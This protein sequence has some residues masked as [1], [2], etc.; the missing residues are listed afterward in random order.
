MVRVEEKGPSSL[1]A[2]TL[3][4]N[5]LGTNPTDTSHTLFATRRCLFFIVF[6]LNEDFQ[7]SKKRIDSLLQSIYGINDSAATRGGG[8][9]IF[10]VGTN[11]EHARCSKEYLAQIQQYVKQLYLGGRFRNTI[12][13]F[14]CVSCKSA[15]VSESARHRHRHRHAHSS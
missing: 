2:L 10:L 7:V 12:E 14:Y 15:A 4:R 11:L 1:L 3:S 5:F 8:A 13:G 6:R 9:T